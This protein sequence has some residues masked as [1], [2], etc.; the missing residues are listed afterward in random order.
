MSTSFNAQTTTGDVLSGV[1][2]TGKRYLVTGVSAG[3]GI[4]TARA[5]VAHGAKVVGTARDLAKARQATHM[6]DPALFSVTALDLADLASVRDCAEHLLATNLPFDAL[7]ANAGVMATPLGYTKDGFETQ[8]GTNHLGHFVLV[9]RLM[10]LV[11][12]GGRVIML[13]SAGHRYGDIDLDD[14]NFERTEYTPFGAYGRSKTANIL[15][16]VALDARHKPRDIRAMAVH[17]GGIATE[18]VRHMPE[19]AIE[20]MV[21]GINRQEAEAG[22]PPFVFKSIPQGAASAVWAATIA[23]PQTIGGR[24]GENCSVSAIVP[25]NEPLGITIPG[26]RAYAVDPARAEALWKLSESMVGETFPTR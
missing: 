26:V 9:N 16:A 6:I 21:E 18:L 22:R 20:A 4:E 7:I 3:L 5:L 1:S 8:F 23:D 15:F 25:D 2:L 11:K 17:P 12:P 10:P 24:Y 19:G 13:S 14:P